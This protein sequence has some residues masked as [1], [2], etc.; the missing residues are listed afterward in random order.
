MAGGGSTSSTCCTQ[1][2]VF[3]RWCP[4]L[5]VA[6]LGFIRGPLNSLAPVYLPT[7]ILLVINLRAGSAGM[8]AAAAANARRALSGAQAVRRAH[9]AFAA[10]KPAGTMPAH[11]PGSR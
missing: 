6:Q 2:L 11:A 10:A 1:V 3:A 4:T 9:P 7:L 8:R 5:A